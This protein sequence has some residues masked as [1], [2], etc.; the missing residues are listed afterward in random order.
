MRE[1]S[2]TET[3]TLV[4]NGFPLAGSMEPMCIPLHF[5]G[6]SFLHPY[7]KLPA[8]YFSLSMLLSAQNH[9]ILIMLQFRK[10]SPIFVIFS[11]KFFLPP[12]QESLGK[13]RNSVRESL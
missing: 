10:H 1:C 9:R 3:V 12:K 4:S 6:T 13:K 2:I 7:D 8:F 11:T 5:P